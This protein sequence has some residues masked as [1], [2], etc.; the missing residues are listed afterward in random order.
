VFGFRDSDL[1]GVDRTDKGPYLD[2]GFKFDPFWS[3]DRATAGRGG[4]R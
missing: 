2:F 4:S 1:T 3:G